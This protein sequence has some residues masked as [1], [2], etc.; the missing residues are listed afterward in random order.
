[1]KAPTYSSYLVTNPGKADYTSTPWGS[2]TAAGNNPYTSAPNQGVV[3]TYDFTISRGVIAPDG[4][5]KNVLLVNGAFPGPPITAN[6]G[7]MI[8]VTVHNNITGPEE[9]T[10]LHWHGLTQQKTPWY[11]GVPSVQ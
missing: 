10:S 7:D 5:Q 9:G 3:R 8:S 6:Y 4:Y 1:M 11:D 2:I